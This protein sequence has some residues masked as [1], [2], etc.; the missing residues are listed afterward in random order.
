MALEDIKKT[1]LATAQKQA[2][3]VKKAGDEKVKEIKAEMQKQLEE[4]KAEFVDMAQRKADQK[5]QQAHFKI[6]A[7]NQ[8]GILKAKQKIIDQVYSEALKKLNQL[9]NNEYINLM[10][11]LIKNLPQTSGQ[12]I[13]AKAKESLLRQAQ[14]KSKTKYQIAKESISAK[15]GFLF[16]SDQIEINNTFESLVETAK[17]KTMLKVTKL[18]FE[19]D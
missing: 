16:K 15:G 8:T 6:A 1:I 9:D 11:K 12:L 2:D 7:S 10:I 13:S 19:Q 17:E 18:L 3:E 5:L 14:E 4:K